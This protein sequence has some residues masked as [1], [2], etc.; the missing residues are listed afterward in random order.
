MIVD[1]N[2]S[3]F[4]VFVCICIGAPMTCGAAMQTYNTCRLQNALVA[5]LIQTIENLIFS[6]K[7]YQFFISLH[8]LDVTCKCSI[9]EKH[10]SLPFVCP[11]VEFSASCTRSISVSNKSSVYSMNFRNIFSIEDRSS[12]MPGLAWLTVSTVNIICVHCRR[13]CCIYKFPRNL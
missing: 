6:G 10:V 4:A 5:M 8:I 13:I 12:V 9:S 2:M 3:Y 11:S 7:F 1:V